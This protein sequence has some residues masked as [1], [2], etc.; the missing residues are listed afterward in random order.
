M[1]LLA[2]SHASAQSLVALG[3]IAEAPAERGADRGAGGVTLDVSGVPLP[4]V[5][6]LLADQADLVLAG[7]DLPQIPVT[8]R[9]HDIDADSALRLIFAGTPYDGFVVGRHLMVCAADQSVSRGFALQRANAAEMA[10]ILIQAYGGST[11]AADPRTNSLV[12][13]GVPAEIR[14]IGDMIAGLDVSVPQILIRADIMEVNLGDDREIGINW[15]YRLNQTKDGVNHDMDATAN[16]LTSVTDFALSYARLGTNEFRAFLGTLQ[17][18]VESRILSSPRVVT[19]SGRTAEILVGERVP[20]PRATTETQTGATMQE[21]EFV[22][23][24]VRLEVTPRIAKDG[25][26]TMLVHPEVSEV[27]DT[28]V[29]GVPRI[30]TREANTEVMIRS[31]ETLVIGGLKRHVRT[32]TVRRLPVLGSIP[33]IGALFRSTRIDQSEVELLV[34]LTPV[35]VDEKLAESSGRQVDVRLRDMGVGAEGW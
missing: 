35:L 23:V 12:V 21:I 31:G 33:L 25:L 29:Q 1:L 20:Y 14:M 30:G 32:E 10:P 16:P 22:E 11:I 13:Q 7:I 26:I 4:E 15:E 9:V 24:G 8:L 2:C 3:L 34:F 5:L 18:V 6:R 19:A 17:E 27:L 28:A